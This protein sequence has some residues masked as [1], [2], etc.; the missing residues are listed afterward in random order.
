MIRKAYLDESFQIIDLISKTFPNSALVRR[1]SKNLE[2]D[3]GAG[4][5][6]SYVFIK[7]GHL[8]G[9]GGVQILEDCG[10]LGGFV[11]D[12]NYRGKGIGKE[13]FQKR[14]IDLEENRVIDRV[15]SYVSLRQPISNDLYD[16]RFIPL[17]L[18]LSI[19]PYSNTES[20]LN[21]GKYSLELVLGWN[22]K[23][24]FKLQIPPSPYSRKIVELYS[25]IGGDVMIRNSDI[26]ECPPME[27][28]LYVLNLS[29]NSSERLK[30][31]FQ[32][33]FIFLG[34][35]PSGREGLKMGGF[36]SRDNL[37]KIKNNLI[38]YISG[39]DRIKFISEIL[40]S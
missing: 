37:E 11:V 24:S 4:K 25:S 10:I 12:R 20:N 19:N 40:N 36:I 28:E 33:K 32:K 13:L 35:L 26:I 31:F 1:G 23:N 6:L 34:I 22:K 38:Y 29:K 17:G 30:Y 8:I 15:V 7:N 14:L 9:H 3:I 2:K 18:S 16:S 39:K 5:Y 21:I 27:E